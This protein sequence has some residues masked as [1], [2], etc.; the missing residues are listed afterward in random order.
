MSL[1]SIKGKLEIKFSRVDNKWI[2]IT[3]IVDA[4]TKSKFEFEGES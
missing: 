3:D 2:T 4:G 1:N